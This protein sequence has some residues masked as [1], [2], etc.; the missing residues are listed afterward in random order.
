M[1]KKAKKAG[2]DEMANLITQSEAAKLRGVSLPSIN[3]LVRRGRLR[4]KEVF[5]KKLV[6]RSEVLAFERETPG[7]KAEKK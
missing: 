3:E 4:T 7:P 1:S 5:G 6:Y 2:D